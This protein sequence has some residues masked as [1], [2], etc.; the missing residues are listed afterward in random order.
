MTGWSD[1]IGDRV[2]TRTMDARCKTSHTYIPIYQRHLPDL[3]LGFLQRPPS[4]RP[5]SKPQQHHPDGRRWAH[6]T[7][8][9]ASQG[10]GGGG[11]WVR[12]AASGGDT[13]RVG[14]FLL[15]GWVG[16]CSSGG[17]VPPT[18]NGIPSTQPYKTN[19][20]CHRPR[21]LPFPRLACSWRVRLATARAALVRRPSFF[22]PLVIYH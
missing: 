9:A 8:G 2:Q 12:R 11:R 13:G 21:S 14:A 4:H 22:L 1:R 16:R 3:H 20:N 19:D 18:S 6:W 7:G 15:C 10:G 5:G 17:L